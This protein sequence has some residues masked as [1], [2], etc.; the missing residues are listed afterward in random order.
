MGT[1]LASFA[2]FVCVTVECVMLSACG[3][4]KIETATPTPIQDSI[5]EESPLTSPM[6]EPTP[7]VSHTQIEPVPT[8]VPIIITKN[9]SSETVFQNDKTWFIAHA[10]N[11]DTIKW[12]F[13][14][15]NGEE[16]TTD[17]LLPVL[18]ELEI[19]ILPDDT[20]ALRNIPL[21]LNGWQ[22]Q[23]EFS[24]NGAVS[25]RTQPATIYVM[26]IP[27]EYLSVIEYYRTVTNYGAESEQALALNGE[28]T[29]GAIDLYRNV[30]S[31]RFGY[32]LR[33]LD[34]DGI[35]ELFISGLG[36]RN[37]VSG[38]DWDNVILSMHTVIDGK[39]STVLE[40]IARGR[41]Y[42]T[43]NNYIQCEGSSG[44][45]YSDWSVYSFYDG[46]LHFVE[47]MWTNGEE[48]QGDAM[49]MIIL[50][51]TDGGRYADNGIRITKEQADEYLV[52]FNNNITPL[53]ELTPI[54]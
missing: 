31:P 1:R 8:S 37:G 38:D 48:Y 9:P 30:N 16:Y 35:P 11:A 52:Y 25:V 44:A 28:C 41:Y 27:R 43:Y 45:A 7:Q 24:G 18:Q 21:S 36:E 17:A 23:A 20:I 26:A 10:D 22:I 34:G 49:N 14:S 5:I 50:Y 47:G 42:L 53:P 4:T 32:F 46:G 40:S 6:P 54:T 29:Y 39:Q 15:P 33:D 51:S 12:F 19:E 13:I 2:L 3:A